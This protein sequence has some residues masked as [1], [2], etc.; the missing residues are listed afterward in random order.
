MQDA[1]VLERV[2]RTLLRDGSNKARSFARKEAPKGP[3]LAG[4]GEDL[5]RPGNA[6]EIGGYGWWMR[7]SFEGMDSGGRIHVDR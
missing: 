5:G 3:G 6:N 2:R 1:H 7:A 4:K